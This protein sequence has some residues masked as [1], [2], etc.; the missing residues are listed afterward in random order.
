MLAKIDATGLSAAIQYPRVGLG[1]SVTVRRRCDEVVPGAGGFIEATNSMYDV[2]ALISA[3][4]LRIL[5]APRACGAIA[6]SAEE[7]VIRQR[8]EQPDRCRL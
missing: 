6:D 3:V 2:H 8:R 7:R 5:S 1:R 4:Y